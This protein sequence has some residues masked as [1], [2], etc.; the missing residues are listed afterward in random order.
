MKFI[1]TTLLLILTAACGYSE[2]NTAF[3]QKNAAND[4]IV[5]NT[6][7]AVTSQSNTISATSKT[8]LKSR[9]EGIWLKEGETECHCGN[10]L[11]IQLDKQIDDFCVESNQIFVSANY[12]M[13]AANN[14]VNLFF[15]D[16]TD[17]GSGGARLPW[18]KYDRQKPLAVIDISKVNENYIT[19]NWQGF[20]EKG[21]A[22]SDAKKYGEWY[23]GRYFKKG[24]KTDKPA[25]PK[26]NNGFEAF[27]AKWQ[28]AF[29]AHDKAV[30]KALMAPDF[31]QSEIG[32]GADAFLKGID[33]DKNFDW[34]FFDKFSA[35]KPRTGDPSENGK[36]TKYVSYDF[37]SATF[38]M[39][40]QNVWQWND[41]T[42]GDD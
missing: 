14:R 13:D 3:K 16:T 4:S 39:N 6:S 40:D 28:T 18:D 35:Q 15:K 1:F 20:S 22:E 30:L 19:V 8:G 21:N 37:C 5:V 34:K 2:S 26:A 10:C 31:S 41:F 17:L 7:P 27:F 11:E 9:V 12:E 38:D 24:A 36:P 25:D 33:T 42:C 29:R 23:A 32:E